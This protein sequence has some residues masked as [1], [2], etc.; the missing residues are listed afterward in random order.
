MRVA[1]IP[2]F[3]VNFPQS[4]SV[5]I[6]DAVMTNSTGAPLDFKVIGFFDVP[7]MSPACQANCMPRPRV[8][9]FVE[10]LNPDSSNWTD[11]RIVRQVQQDVLSM[12]RPIAPF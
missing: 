10:M 8:V 11:E 1:M 7:E 3:F 4:V 5:W 9:E 2:G 6:C 12:V